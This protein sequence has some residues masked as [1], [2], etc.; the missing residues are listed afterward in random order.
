M[1]ELFLWTTNNKC[2]NYLEEAVGKSLYLPE[3]FL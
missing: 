3:R 2:I 1:R